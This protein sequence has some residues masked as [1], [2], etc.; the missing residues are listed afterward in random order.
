MKLMIKCKES[1][2]LISRE[3]DEK[4]GVYKKMQLGL[5]LIVCKS[6]PVVLQNFQNLR[7]QIKNWRNYTDS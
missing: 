3:L 6:C 5:H 7:K 1:S 4:L 2:E